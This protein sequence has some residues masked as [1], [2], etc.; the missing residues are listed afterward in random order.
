M[1][2]IRTI[3]FRYAIFLLA[4]LL[5]SPGI[6][7]AATQPDAVPTILESDQRHRQVSR[8]VTRFVE[9]AHYSKISVDDEL[10]A[11]ILNNY[12]NAL[13]ANKHYFRESD[14]TYFNRYQDSL[15]DVLRSGDFNPVFDILGFVIGRI[16]SKG[17]I[18]K[19]ITIRK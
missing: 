6:Y 3:I 14:I 19:D 4:A 17:Y 2:S 12:I 11:I 5:T 13:D 16:K 8:M 1:H 15:D 10:S 7:A 18:L 9:R